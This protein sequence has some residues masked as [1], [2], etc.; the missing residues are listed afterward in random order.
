MTG[1]RDIRGIRSD[2]TIPVG[3]RPVRCG[4]AYAHSRLTASRDQ[5]GGV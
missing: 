3:V 5:A 2:E 4:R 1:Q